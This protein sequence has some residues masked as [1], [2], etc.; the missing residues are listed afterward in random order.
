MSSTVYYKSLDGFRALAVLMVVMIH[1]QWL[2]FGWVGV[3]MFFVL[4]GFLITGILVASNGQKFPDYIGYFYW[5]RGLRIWPLFFLFL[6]LTAISYRTVGL[7]LGFSACWP[8]L[9]TYTYNFLRIWKQ[10]DSNWFGHFW[11]LC[12]EEQFYLV[13][14]FI[15]YFLSMGNLRRLVVTLIVMGPLV[16]L[17]TG[18]AFASIFSDPYDIQIAVNNMTTSQMDAFACGALLAILPSHLRDRLASRSGTILLVLAAITIL[19]GLLNSWVLARHH[20]PPHWLALGYDSMCY[21]HQYVWG[22]TLLN[23]TSAGLILCLL[24]DRL[25]SS[26]FRHP[27]MIYIGTISYGVY[28]WHLPLLSVLFSYWPV[29]AHTF[30]GLLRF[31]LLLASSLAVASVSYFGFEWFFLRLKGRTG[32]KAQAA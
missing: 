2:P 32:R 9:V 15:V 29:E 6:A 28:V 27:V 12:L 31:A 25:F 23:L 24:D 19:C 16:R 26:F 1:S 17:L 20:L 8:T 7:P 5:K 30:L 18:M 10:Y 11:T 4:S 14:P 21:L 22:Y 3:Q 13:W